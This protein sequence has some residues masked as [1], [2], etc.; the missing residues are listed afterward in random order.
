[1]VSIDS[2][3]G[4][5]KQLPFIGEFLSVPIMYLILLAY[6]LAVLI[7]LEVSERNLSTYCFPICHS[8]S[9]YTQLSEMGLLF[10]CR[11]AYS[12]YLL[13]YIL[14]TW[15]FFGKFG[16]KLSNNLARSI[17][18]NPGVEFWSWGSAACLFARGW[19]SNCL[20]MLL[21]VPSRD[22]IEWEDVWSDSQA[23]QW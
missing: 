4:R 1:M 12:S 17:K 14:E 9:I 13:T 23:Y 15:L 7:N 6:I 21:F 20:D 2:A 19:S 11:R 18:F 5:Y 10:V 16:L 22:A 8:V 3:S